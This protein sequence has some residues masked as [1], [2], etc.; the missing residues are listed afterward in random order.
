VCGLLKTKE[1][2]DQTTFDFL[3]ENPSFA[4]SKI[5]AFCNDAAFAKKRLT[6][7]SAR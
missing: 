6:S 7:R 1:R 3:K 2:T 5:V 4:F